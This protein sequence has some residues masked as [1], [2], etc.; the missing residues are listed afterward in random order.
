MVE[1]YITGNLQVS[2]KVNDKD[3]A[4]TLGEK[5]K[6]P[7]GSVDSKQFQKLLETLK[8]RAQH[9]QAS[10]LTVGDLYHKRKQT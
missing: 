2:V 3:I 9:T 7:L 8:K 5:V 4:L 6:I 10:E 1:F